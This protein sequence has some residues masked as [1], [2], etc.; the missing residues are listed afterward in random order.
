MS[1]H[2]LNGLF[3]YDT[4]VNRNLLG[5][6]EKSP[7]SGER[8]EAIFAHILAARKIWMERLTNDGRSETPV[9][10]VLDFD[11]CAALI[12]ENDQSYKSYLQSKSAAHLMEQ[13]SYQNSEG[14]RF[15]ERPCDILMHVVIHGGYHRGQIAQAMRRAGGESINTDYIF[16]LRHR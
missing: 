9:W 8:T 12:E 11:Q 10:P 16:H 1:P 15:D 2:Y 13:V 3:E 6:L 14:T 5:A 7:G 4:A